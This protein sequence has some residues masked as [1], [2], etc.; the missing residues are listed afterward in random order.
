MSALL[1]NVANMKRNQ[2]QH[3]LKSE[4][5]LTNNLHNAYVEYLNE[6]LENHNLIE[7]YE[8]NVDEIRSATKEELATYDIEPD[9][10]EL[11]LELLASIPTLTF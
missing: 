8:G 11:H 1:S 6:V 9:D 4:F 10:E 2:L 3:I 5:I 7:F